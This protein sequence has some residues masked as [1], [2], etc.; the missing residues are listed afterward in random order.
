MGKKSLLFVIH[1]LEL[2]GAEMSLI[3]LLESIDYSKYDV[4]LFVHAHRGELMKAIP[5]QVNLLHEIP[6]YA[7]IERPIAKVVKSGY[8]KIAAARL[9]AKIE[10]GRYARKKRPK[11]GSAVFAYAARRTAP[12]MPPFNPGKVYDLAV[13]YLAPHDYVLSKVRAKEKICWIHTDYSQIDVNTVLEFPVW[14]G[15]DRIAALSRSTLKAFAEV[16]PELEDKLEIIPNKLPLNYIRK[17]A[18]EISPEEIEK[19]MPAAEGCVKLLSVGRFCQAKNYDN[20]PDICLQINNELAAPVRAV[21]YLIGFGQD[22]ALILEKVKEDCKPG[23]VIVLGKKENPYPYMKACDY[24]VQPSRYEG[25]PVTVHEAAAL[26]KEVILTDFPTATD[27]AASIGKVNIVPLD[28]PGC[29]EAIAS[30]IK[31]R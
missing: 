18:D 20:V 5:P 21:W 13:S 3:G 6:E 30:I 10:Y 31:A 9:L 2:G 26:G 7:Q 28:N 1:Y 19:E 23:Q 14:N 17:K 16:F 22:E 29:A 15:Y 8:L 11:D 27:V 4:D 25:D 12:F 24:Y